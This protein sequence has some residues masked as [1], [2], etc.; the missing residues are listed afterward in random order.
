MTGG[1]VLR[2]AVA[3]AVLEGVW[4]VALG[5]G[6]GEALYVWVAGV[7]VAWAVAVAR[8][9]AERRRLAALEARARGE[10]VATD[11]VAAP[12]VRAL[13]RLRQERDAAR[14]AVAER[15]A[16]LDAIDDGVLALRPDG[17]VR[18][19]NAAARALLGLPAEARGLRPEEVSR[20]PQFRR[21]LEEARA[22]GAAQ[23]ELTVR[24]RRLLLKARPLPDGDLAVLVRDVTELR[25]LEEVRRDFVANAS[26]ELQTPLTILRGYGE[27]LLE[28]D[29]PPALRRQFAERILRG[30]ER[31][32]HLVDNLLDLSRL[33]SGAW[34]LRPR[35]VALAAAA[36]DAWE[37]VGGPA[38]PLAFAVACPPPAAEAWADPDA[39]GRILANVLTNAIRHTPAGGRIEVGSR[40]DAGGIELWVRDT[41]SGIPAVHLP[42]IFE[43]FY[44]VDP[45]R[46]RAE[47]GSGLGL[48]IVRH[49]VEA[50]GGWVRAE[51]VLGEGTTIRLWL[52][53]PPTTDANLP[54]ACDPS[55][56]DDRDP[57]SS[58]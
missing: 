28:D 57:A 58:P 42:R 43:R 37:A 53:D 12:L 39:L 27:T 45:G 22:A 18:R 5:R 2:A 21:L 8:A 52:P 54:S 38:H 10:A 7:A 29:L 51:S 46:A 41:G 31:L 6:L 56:S 26:H 3:L 34:P 9:R 50:H 19:A 11:P 24:G 33:E 49:L 35:W 15:E 17:R 1:V 25:R 55:I 47:G 14:R 4:M 30:V 13:E 20:R 16:L 44:R 40:R 32:Q 48:A 36:H 23:A